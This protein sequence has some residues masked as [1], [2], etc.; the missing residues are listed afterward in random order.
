MILIYPMWMSRTKHEVKKKQ[1]GAQ[2][3]KGRKLK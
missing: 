2:V 1:Q 3:F